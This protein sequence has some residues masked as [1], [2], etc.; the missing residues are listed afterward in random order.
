MEYEDAGELLG[1]GSGGAALYSQ[2]YLDAGVSDMFVGSKDGVQL[3]TWMIS[4]VELV[5]M[6]Q[7]RAT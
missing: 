2:K 6:L 4:F 7:M 5:S 3:S 1:Q